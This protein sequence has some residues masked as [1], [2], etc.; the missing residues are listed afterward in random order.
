VA[1]LINHSNGSIAA[2]CRYGGRVG[3]KELA[4]DE[5]GVLPKWDGM[6]Q[7]E[8]HFPNSLPQSYNYSLSSKEEVRIKKG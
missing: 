1:C 2:W 6:N 3:N 8:P 4:E 5:G 7:S